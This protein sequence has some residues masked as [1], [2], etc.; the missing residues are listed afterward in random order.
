MTT[1]CLI[2]EADYL[3]KPLTTRDLNAVNREELERAALAMIRTAD[4][5]GV[6]MVT[7][8]IQCRVMEIADAAVAGTEGT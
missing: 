7:V 4:M 5:T 3:G 6:V 8:E 1:L 2:P